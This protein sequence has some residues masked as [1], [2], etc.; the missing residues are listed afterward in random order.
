ML[1]SLVVEPTN[2]GEVVSCNIVVVTI[3]NQLVCK[4]S[5]NLGRV[6]MMKETSTKKTWIVG[7]YVCESDKYVNRSIAINVRFIQTM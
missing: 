4:I 6:C 7:K 1:Q 5:K 2:S 3:A